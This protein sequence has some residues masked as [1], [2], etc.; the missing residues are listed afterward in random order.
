MI[1]RTLK[2]SLLNHDR[3]TV[4]QNLTDKFEID[5]WDFLSQQ[6]DPRSFRSDEVRGYAAFHMLR[7]GKKHEHSFDRI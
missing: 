5:E 4:K 2:N 7:P 1:S 6:W 3:T